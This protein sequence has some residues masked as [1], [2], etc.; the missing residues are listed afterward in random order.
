MTVGVLKAP[1]EFF[2]AYV[3]DLDGTVY[4]GDQLLRG[5]ARLIREVRR[6]GIPIVPPHRARPGGREDGR[7]GYRDVGVGSAQGGTSSSTTRR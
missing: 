4:L 7:G 5:A 2:D 3:L 6:R 1:S